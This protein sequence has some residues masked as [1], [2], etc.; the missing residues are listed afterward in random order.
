MPR[1]NERM[2][3]PRCGRRVELFETK[4]NGD[5]VA[6]WLCGYRLR[7]KP[8]LDLIQEGECLM[9]RPQPSTPA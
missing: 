4:A 2:T 7:W 5:E 8:G 6:V 3:C 9:E 1:F